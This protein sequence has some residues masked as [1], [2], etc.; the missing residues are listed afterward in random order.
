MVDRYRDGPPTLRYF[1]LGLRGYVARFQGRPN[2]AAAIYAQS[3]RIDV[4]AGTYLVNRTAEARAVFDRGD[5]AHAFAMLRDHVAAILDTDHVDVTRMVAVEFVSMTAEA[6]HLAESARVLAYLDTTGAFGVLAR[7]TLV[8]DAA[9]RIA[10]EPPL[11]DNER[12]EFD[13]YRA[14]TYM[15]DVLTDLA[16]T[17]YAT[18][19]TGVGSADG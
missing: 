6:E 19:R 9:R 18:F 7:E 16:T 14:L 3:A 1:G 13:D 8:A 15:R 11:R 12:P 5:H 4:P 17:G 10:A 2:D